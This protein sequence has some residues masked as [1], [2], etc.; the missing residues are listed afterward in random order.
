MERK[1]CSETYDLSLNPGPTTYYLYDIKKKKAL[2]LSFP[3]CKMNGLNKMNTKVPSN[4][5][6]MLL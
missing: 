4:L 1:L 3:M 5:I 2:C 6:F